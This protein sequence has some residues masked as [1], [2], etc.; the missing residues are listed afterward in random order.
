[1]EEEE[2]KQILQI[3]NFAIAIWL[4]GPS[5]QDQKNICD[6]IWFFL[7]LCLYIWHL[8]N[9]HQNKFIF[10]TV[11]DSF[12]S[13]KTIII[14]ATYNIMPLGWTCVLNSRE[15]IERAADILDS[16]IRSLAHTVLALNIIIGSYAYHFLY[17][18]N[19]LWYSIIWINRV[20]ILTKKGEKLWYCGWPYSKS[21]HE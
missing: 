20:I 10:F 14:A 12:W 6:K 15:L 11:S 18:M 4:W 19:F 16:G 2:N 9:W 3:S 5:K 7:K 21:W 13:L 8:Y 1:M 17:M